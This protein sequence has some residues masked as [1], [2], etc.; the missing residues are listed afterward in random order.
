MP[1]RAFLSC[2]TAVRVRTDQLPQA[3]THFRPAFL[4][5]EYTARTRSGGDCTEVGESSPPLSPSWRDILILA[6]GSGLE[7]DG[8]AR[9]VPEELRSSAVTVLTTLF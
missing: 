2:S 5:A 7:N 3:K 1:H 6:L 8:I 9:L 4:R